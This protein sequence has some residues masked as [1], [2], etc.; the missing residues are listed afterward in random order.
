[1]SFSDQFIFCIVVSF[2]L[3]FE[4]K[5]LYVEMFRFNSTL[6]FMGILTLLVEK[7]EWGYKKRES[8][9]EPGWFIIYKIL[10]LDVDAS[11]FQNHS[12]IRFFLKLK[13][14]K[15][16]FKFFIKFICLVVVCWT[17]SINFFCDFY[18]WERIKR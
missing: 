5:L 9:D 17:S 15:S 1:M 4:K 13:S 11:F 7:E 14:T 16:V 2:F 6:P 8:T 18:F 3:L 12:L 10:R